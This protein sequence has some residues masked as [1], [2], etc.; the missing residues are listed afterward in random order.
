MGKKRGAGKVGRHLFFHIGWSVPP[1]HE[2]KRSRDV[3]G[4]RGGGRGG[5]PAE[6]SGQGQEQ[7]TAREVRSKGLPTGFEDEKEK[8]GG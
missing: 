2:V 7:R 4:T 1:A 3:Q 6:P 8:G 5:G